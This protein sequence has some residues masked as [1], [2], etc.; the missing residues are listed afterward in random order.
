M[1]EFSHKTTTKQAPHHI[2]NISKGCGP[3]KYMAF[4]KKLFWEVSTPLKNMS[5]HLANLVLHLQLLNNIDYQDIHAFLSYIRWVIIK[6]TGSGV[7]SSIIGRGIYSCSHT[8]KKSISKVMNDAEHEYM[9]TS[10]P[11]IELATPLITGGRCLS[12]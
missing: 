5:I 1:F 2:L 6:V 10:P 12:K 9:N 3:L 4:F 7:A 8:V 11:I